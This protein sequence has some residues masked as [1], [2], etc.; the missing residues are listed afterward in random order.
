[1]NAVF[2]DTAFYVA[3]VN[4]HDEWHVAATAFVTQFS[5]RIV[6]TE[7]VLMEVAN[8]FSKAAKRAAFI[9][10]LADLKAGEETE[11]VSSSAELFG[12]AV[13]LFT[14]RPDKDWS[15]TDCTSFVT[16]TDRGLTDALTVDRHFEQ[17]GFRI[18]L[19]DSKA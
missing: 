6:T 18:L 9:D 1:M 11:I 12:R 15:L 7:F 2:A 8:F 17:A 4:P 5:G 14:R 3:A 19:T 16:M 10:L 13:D